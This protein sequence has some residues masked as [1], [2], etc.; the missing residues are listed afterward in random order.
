MVISSHSKSHTYTNGPN[1]YPMVLGY[2]MVT[3][4]FCS[5]LLLSSWLLYSSRMIRRFLISSINEEIWTIAT[6]RN[7]GISGYI[8]SFSQG[9]IVQRY[10]LG[11][12]RKMAESFSKNIP[13]HKK[14]KQKLLFCGISVAVTDP[15][16]TILHFW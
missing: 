9:G 5:I 3:R 11:D 2:K 16:H 12:D 15:T 10:H 4:L 14:Q 1:K 13:N 8:S 6:E 7:A